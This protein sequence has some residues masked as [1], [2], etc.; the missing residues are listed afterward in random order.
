MSAVQPTRADRVAGAELMAALRAL[1]GPVLVIRHPWY[2]TLAGKGSF[3]QSEGMT[4]ILRSQAPR[5]ARALRR[6]AR[7][8]S[9]PL[10]HQGGG[11]RRQ[12]RRAAA[13]TGAAAPVPAR[14]A[15]D[16]AR[17]A[18][19]ADRHAVG[20]DAL[21]RQG[22]SADGSADPVLERPRPTQVEALHDVDPALAP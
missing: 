11:A 19:R 8:R 5:G 4:D 1:R 6:L 18:V 13:R 15:F 2:G 14:L 3:A 21:L 16:H 17:A 22:R 7:E 9:R 10:S 12:L 20:A